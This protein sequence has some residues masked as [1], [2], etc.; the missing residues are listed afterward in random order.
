MDNRTTTIAIL[1]LILILA[2]VLIFQFRPS[3]SV[4][5]VPSGTST[6]TS[7]GSGTGSTM[8][9]SFN[10]SVSDGTI[11]IAYPAQTF[12]LAVNASQVLVHSYIPPCDEG[13]NYCVYYIGTQY[14]GT[15][16]ESAGIRVKKRTDLTNERLCVTTPPEG[17][18]ATTEPNNTISTDTYVSSIFASVG[19]GAAGHTS[20]G[21]LYRLF[22][23]GTGTCYEFETRV[24]QS[25]FANYPAGS[26]K[27][28][29]VSDQESV[30]AQLR[31]II[32]S[33]RFADS[34]NLFP[35]G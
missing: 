35:Q 22:I 15:N 31:A 2:I 32:Q 1:I 4:I 6:G 25:Q 8:P 10:Q 30:L 19:Q 3:S 23:R 14:Q 16:F 5:V 34:A 33:I 21:S 29:T 12:G 28:F 17:F 9:S 13:F 18:A 11:T 20:S 27:E 26:I 24:G 7:T